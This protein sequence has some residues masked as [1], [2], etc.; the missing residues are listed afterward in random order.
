MCLHNRVQ[1]HAPGF[2]CF[3][4]SLP[5]TVSPAPEAQHRIVMLLPRPRAQPCRCHPRR[6]LPK[7]SSVGTLPIHRGALRARHARMLSEGLCA[8]VNRAIAQLAFAVWHLGT[9]NVSL[10]FLMAWPRWPLPD[11]AARGRAAPAHRGLSGVHALHR[12][13]C[14]K[15]THG[16]EF[17]KAKHHPH[18][19][20]RSPTA[21][22]NLQ[23]RLEAEEKKKK[24][25]QRMN[26]RGEWLRLN[27]PPQGPPCSEG[28]FVFWV[29]CLLF[30]DFYFFCP[31][32]RLWQ[33]VSTK[34]RGSA[35]PPQTCSWSLLKFSP[36]RLKGK[37]PV[38][39]SGPCSEWH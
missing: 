24:M 22:V 29:C 17:Q 12:Q 18:I 28:L 11:S 19:T 36:N 32:W 10:Q 31:F 4:A 23:L 6:V 15:T 7:A 9:E 3:G 33:S 20:D 26:F 13:V 37:S 39:E 35:H 38:Y 14:L 2:C 8:D 16:W 25:A 21:G 34:T 1:R 27:N 30:F 5:T